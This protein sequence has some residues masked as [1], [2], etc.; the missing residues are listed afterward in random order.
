MPLA[1]VL[2]ENADKLAGWRVEIV[3]TD[4]SSEV[5]EKAKSGLYSQFEAQR[6][7]PIQMLVKYFSQTGELWQI[8]GS[9]RAM[10]DFKYFNLL[11]D[12]A[13]L[14]KFDVVFCRNVLIYF[15][16]ET[17]AQVLNRIAKILPPDGTMY[18]GA[19]ETVIGVSENFRPVK[20][21]RGVYELNTVAAE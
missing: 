8:D 18:L 20:G 21:K 3:A 11:D 4:I 16:Q 14:G 17:K 12:P 2:K 19:A 1:M 5:L 15:D 6:G 10:V 9:L 13:R 7:L